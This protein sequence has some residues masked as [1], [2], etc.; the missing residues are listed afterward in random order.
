MYAMSSS[1][2]VP[3]IAAARP[4]SRRRLRLLLLL[5]VEVIV[6]VLLLEVSLRVGY[7]HSA[8]LRRMLYMSGVHTRYDAAPDLPELM[9]MTPTGWTPRRRNSDFILNSMGLKTTEYEREKAPGT[10]RVVVLGDSFTFAS[11]GVPY[12]NLWHVRMGELLAERRAIPV[13]TIS[14]GVRAVG[15]DFYRRMWEVEGS[16][17][18]ADLVVVG[19]FVG[20]DLRDLVGQAEGFEALARV[21][22]TVRLV[23]HWYRNRT[24]VALSESKEK[25]RGRVYDEGG[26]VLPKYTKSYDSERPTLSQ[27]AFEQIHLRR[28]R[29]FAD[30]HVAELDEGMDSIRPHMLALREQVEASGAKL[31]VMLIPGETQVNPDL[32]ATIAEKMRLAPGKYDITKPNRRLVEWLAKEGIPYLDLLTAFQASAADTKLYKM[33]DTHWNIEGNLLAAEKLTT[34]LLE[35]ILEN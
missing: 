24:G 6:V 26:V 1:V 15:M 34:F 8:N 20:N 16:R 10:Y 12:K 19:F 35:N 33:H 18:G 22:Y 17:L 3:T 30:R 32:E 4:Q 31:A 9:S 23:R 14:L 5:L 7:R 27:E 28:F 13:E 2:D 21:S 25:N 11:A 29:V